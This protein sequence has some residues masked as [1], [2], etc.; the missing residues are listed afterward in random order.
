MSKW[1]IRG[2]QPVDRA[3]DVARACW[4]ALQ[5]VDPE[6]AEVIALAAET[7]GERWLRPQPSQ[8]GPDDVVTV[9][10]GAELIGRSA[11]WVYAWVARDRA[12]RL[13]T[14]RDG[15]MRVRVRDLLEYAA[16]AHQED[17]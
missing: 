9:I 6:A 16:H 12:H 10:E 13:V 2:A 5:R 17:F 7:A 8:Y 15:R 4:T 14:G 11:R 3:R 1:P